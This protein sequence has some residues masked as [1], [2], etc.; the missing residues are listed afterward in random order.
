MS[1]KVVIW[2]KGDVI[3]VGSFGKVY[4]GFNTDSG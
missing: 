3:G 4:K 2:Q 1:E